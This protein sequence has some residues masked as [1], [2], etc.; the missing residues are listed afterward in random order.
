MKHEFL[1]EYETYFGKG[2]RFQVLAN[3][4]AEALKLGKRYLEERN[5]GGNVIIDSL[6]VIRKLK[7]S[8]GKEA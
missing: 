5:H 2:P 3:D 8:F 4:R 7:P 6:K 1:L